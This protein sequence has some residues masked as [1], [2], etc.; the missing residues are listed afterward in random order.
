MAQYNLRLPAMGEGVIEA[1]IIH[2]LSEE[3][4]TVELDQTLLEIAT[5]KV[6]S[7]IP[8]PV[9]GKLIKKCFDSNQTVKVGETLAVIE[10]DLNHAESKQALLEEKTEEIAFESHKNQEVIAPISAL[11]SV[12]KTREFLSPAV[13]LMMVKENIT[14][15]ELLRIPGTGI[16]GRITIKDL[17][18]YLANG[19]TI[20]KVIETHSTFAQNNQEVIQ[21]I[22]P[23]ILKSIDGKYKIIEVDRMRR[24]IARNML[25]SMEIAAHVTSFIEVDVTNIVLWRESNKAE[26]LEKYGVKLT[27][28]PVFFQIVAKALEDF[29]KINISLYDNWIIQK[30]NI[31]IGMATALPDGNLIVPVIKNANKLSLGELALQIDHFAKL[32]RENKLKPEDTQGGTYTLSNI[33][34]FGNA[35]GTPIINQPQVAILAIGTIEK[36]P[37]VIQENGKDLIAIRHKLFLSHT[38]DHRIIDGMLGGSFINHISKLMQ[39]F[40]PN[41]GL[42]Q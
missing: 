11:D 10:I 9:K 40:D 15:D 8:S 17:E 27:Y 2:W 39:D 42:N 35:M 19:K 28:L 38:Y 16:A 6:D 4:D 36:K 34:S 23:E 29:P 13:K 12:R 26:F 7:E 32:A 18:K 31:N 21:G 41:A 22:N 33:G 5:D 24:S 1:K 37:A 20:P 25:Q 30:E 3:G 14:L